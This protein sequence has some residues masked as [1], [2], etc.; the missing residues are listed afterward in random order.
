MPGDLQIHQNGFRYSPI[1]G[2]QKV[3]ILFSNI[4]HLFFQPCDNELYVVLHCHLHN[5]IMVNKK[6]TKD[7]QFLREASEAAFDETSNRRRRYQHGDEDELMAE[8]D[9]RRRRQ[10]LNKEFKAF[11]EKVHEISGDLEA[12]VPIRELGFNGVPSRSNVFLVPTTECLVHLLEP[13]FLVV[14]LAEVEMAYLER[15]QFHL[16]NFD[17]V[18]VMRDFSRTPVHINSIPM[19]QL[20]NIKEWLDSV[21]I[22]FMEGPYNLNWSAIMKNVNEDPA[23]F[24]EDGG[25]ANLMADTQG[26]ESEEESASE[27]EASLASSVEAST[28]D[29]DSDAD[30]DADE[31]A[32]DDDSDASVAAESGSEGESGEDWDELEIKAKRSDERKAAKHRGSD[33]EGDEDLRPKK[34]K[35]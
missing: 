6:K 25:W 14:T 9:E 21:D 3:D 13:P 7:I 31:D 8:Q 15:V 33:D 22:L 23:G 19:N 18:F 30:S 32:D 28:D 34:K 24:Y 16:K 2:D 5:P 11:A 27:Y 10:K 20:E 29:D 17:I 1:R 4:K 26:E 12:D 35:R